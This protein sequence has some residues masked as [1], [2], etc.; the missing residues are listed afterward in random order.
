MIGQLVVELVD[1][2]AFKFT[3]IVQLEGVGEPVDRNNS[4][5]ATAW[6]TSLGA[7]RISSTAPQAVA[8]MPAMHD[9]S[10]SG[11]HLS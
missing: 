1:T 11:G 10:R 6:W 2:T 9:T 8:V 3:K 4:N 7:D 5:R